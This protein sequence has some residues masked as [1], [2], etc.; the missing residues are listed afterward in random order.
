MH[1]HTHI[2]TQIGK[3]RES[4]MC[5]DNEPSCMF[6]LP[7][8]KVHSIWKLTWIFAWSWLFPPKKL[9]NALSH[10]LWLSSQKVMT[11]CL[12]YFFRGKQQLECFIWLSGSI[13]ARNRGGGGTNEEHA[14]R[15]QWCSK[16]LKKL[17]EAYSLK[18]SG[19]VGIEQGQG[20][21]VMGKFRWMRRKRKKKGWGKT[22]LKVSKKDWRKERGRGNVWQEKVEIRR[23]KQLLWCYNI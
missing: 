17:I 1:T 14:T 19:V 23:C 10:Q 12:C 18:S 4:Y 7:W 20:V 3:E 11:V 9:I 2:H 22:K 15:G 8:V 6:V 13:T 5:Y 21:E 16:D